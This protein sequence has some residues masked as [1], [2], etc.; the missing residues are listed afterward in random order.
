MNV[1]AY[2]YDADYH[3]PACA[4]ERFRGITHGLEPSDFQDSEGNPPH[5][6]FDTD[7][8][9]ANDIYEGNSKATLYCGDC[10]EIIEELEL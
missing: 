3:C 10:H 9:F 7:E 8:W 1:I 5:P 4:E 6:L 2:T